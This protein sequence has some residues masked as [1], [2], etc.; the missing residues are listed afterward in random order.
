M[1]DPSSDHQ[2]ADGAEDRAPQWRVEGVDEDGPTGSRWFQ[3]MKRRTFWF[4]VGGLLFVNW[5]IASTLLQS[6]E[7]QHFPYTAFLSEVEQKM[8]AL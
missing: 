8:A 2:R 6:A 5:V 3:P 7:P 1:S 4:L